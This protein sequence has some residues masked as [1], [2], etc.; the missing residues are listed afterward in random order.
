MSAVARVEAIVDVQGSIRSLSSC[1]LV[2]HL[3]DAHG[4]RALRI[5]ID[6]KHVRL[7]YM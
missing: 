5:S 1:E 7:T 6:Y 2:I 4:D 3:D